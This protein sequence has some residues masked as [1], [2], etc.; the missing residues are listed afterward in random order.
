MATEILTDKQIAEA[1]KSLCDG[2]GLWLEVERKGDRFLKRWVFY[3]PH[4]DGERSTKK[5]GSP[6][7]IKT[8]QIGIG[9][10]AVVTASF[11][12]DQAIQFR[13]WVK[14][15]IDPIS[16]RAKAAAL[17]GYTVRTALRKFDKFVVAQQQSKEYQDAIK[18]HMAYI[19]PRIGHYHPSVCTPPFLIEKLHY[20]NISRGNRS[21]FQNCLIG[22]FDMAVFDGVIPSNP[23]TKSSGIRRYIPK[24]EGETVSHGERALPRERLWELVAGLRASTDDRGWDGLPTRTISSY[25]SEFVVVTGVRVSEVYK[26]KWGAINEATRIWVVPKTKNRLRRDVRITSTMARVLKDVR[27]IVKAHGLPAGD[28]DP[29]FPKIEG[30]ETD[31]QRYSRGAVLT[32]LNKVCAENGLPKM[33]THSLRTNLKGW[34]L[35]MAKHGCAHYPQLVEIQLAHKVKGKVAQA[36]SAQD[37]DWAERCKMMERYDEFCT[38]E[39]ADRSNVIA[40]SKAEESRP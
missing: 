20:E 14:A 31:G 34:G 19:E 16:A 21:G 13:K 3:Y 15:G 10:V 24:A 6:G 26:A 39:P 33:T 12:R 40:F 18:R 23:A 29:V 35:S 2:E 9:S 4:L 25:L 37:D 28:N 17:A 30:K 7:A 27:E 8:R 32:H 22:V 38:T 1:T 11:A 5:D 36:Y